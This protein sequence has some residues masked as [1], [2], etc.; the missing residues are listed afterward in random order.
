VASSASQPAKQA[1]LRYNKPYTIQGREKMLGVI[2]SEIG[3]IGEFTDQVQIKK[4]I[5]EWIKMREFQMEEKWEP[6]ES[7]CVWLGPS[8]T[9]IEVQEG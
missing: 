2:H 4:F 3:V 9:W 8:G 1:Q 6:T 7:E 5:K